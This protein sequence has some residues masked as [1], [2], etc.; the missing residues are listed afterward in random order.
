MKTKKA[1]KITETIN[2]KLS[3]YFLESMNEHQMK[4]FVNN[5]KEDLFTEKDKSLGWFKAFKIEVLPKAVIQKK[6]SKEGTNNTP[7]IN[8]LILRPLDILAI[9]IPTN[10]DHEIHQAQ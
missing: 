8:S 9:N 5:I 1:R 2:R 4:T 3:V 7:R 6:V 10:G